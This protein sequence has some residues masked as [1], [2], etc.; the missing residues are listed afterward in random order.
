MGAEYD[1]TDATGIHTVVWFA[2][3]GSGVEEAKIKKQKVKLMRP[4]AAVR[5]FWNL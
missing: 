5:A 1:S 4:S 3:E 2:V